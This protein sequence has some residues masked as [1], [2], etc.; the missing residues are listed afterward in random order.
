[1][2]FADVL[3]ELVLRLLFMEMVISQNVGSP[4]LECCSSENREQ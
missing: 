4:P 3:A 2:F 1:M